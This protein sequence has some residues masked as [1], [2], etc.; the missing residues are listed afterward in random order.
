[1]PLT[2][3]MKQFD[4][5]RETWSSGVDKM[6]KHFVISCFKRCV[7]LLRHT[8]EWARGQKS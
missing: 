7:C 6:E 1:M 4:M 8:Y 3:A 5:A 2:S